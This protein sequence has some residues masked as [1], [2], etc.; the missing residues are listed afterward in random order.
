MIS[1]LKLQLINYD[2]AQLIESSSSISND[3]SSR[4][5]PAGVSL[6]HDICRFG[7][8]PMPAYINPHTDPPIREPIQRYPRAQYPLH[9]VV[10]L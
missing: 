1:Y 2:V 10:R 3:D 9:C 7:P 4:F 5:G 6:P 8:R